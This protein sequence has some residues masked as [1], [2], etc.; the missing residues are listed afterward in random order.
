[1]RDMARWGVSGILDRVFTG[2]IRIEEDAGKSWRSILGINV[3][4]PTLEE[5]K[6]AYHSKMLKV[7]PDINK[8][9]TGEAVVLNEAY[10]KALSELR[11]LEGVYS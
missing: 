8:S 1:M 11:S 9:D 2:F 4:E 3:Q 7:H 5:I 6:K 10:Q